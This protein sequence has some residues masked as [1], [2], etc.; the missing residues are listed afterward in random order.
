MDVSHGTIVSCC[1][2]VT[3]KIANVI[4]GCIRRDMFR[5]EREVLIFQELVVPHQECSI[6]FWLI[7]LKKNKF[8]L[9]QVQRRAYLDSL[10][11]RAYLRK[12]D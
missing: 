5:N 11:W 8:K 12:G 4:L 6:P 3:M 9:E 10:G 7:M 1:C 2:D